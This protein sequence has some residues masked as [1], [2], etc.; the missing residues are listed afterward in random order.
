MTGNLL[1]WLDDRTPLPATDQAMGPDSEAPGL[2]A[3][4]GHV[5]PQR[6]EEAY[7]HGVFPWFNPGDPPLWWAPDP[8]MVLPV[9]EFHATHSLRK[10]LRRFIRTP[11]CEVRI[12]S[13]FA[14]V[15]A[16]CADTPRDGQRGTWIVD[17]IVAAYT[18]WHRLGRAHSV[19]TWI[20][21]QL[22]GGLYGVGIGRMFY[23][24]SMFSHRTDASKIALCALVAFCRGHGITL[25][26]CQQHTR[27]LASFGARQIPRRDFEAHLART[28]G[29]PPPAAWTYDPAFWALLD[30]EPAPTEP[31]APG[32]P[33]TC[34]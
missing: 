15:M 1:T 24:E 30:L 9:A 34:A 33:T 16:A 31:P 20:D 18:A 23:G 13:A 21:G 29:A 11:G 4:G 28:L 25:I 8:R 14:A 7:R 6:L 5:T 12:D 22:V 26:D 3:A 32:P 2:L 10:T 19:E 17:E 27:H